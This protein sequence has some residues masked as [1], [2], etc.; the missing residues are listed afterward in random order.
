MTL[1]LPGALCLISAFLVVHCC[2]NFTAK[3]SYA[4]FDTFD[5]LTINNTRPILVLYG[6]YF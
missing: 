5:I 4:K 1:L 2:T 6:F 3:E